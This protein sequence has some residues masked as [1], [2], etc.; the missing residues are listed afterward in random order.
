MRG[1]H[2]VCNQG[3]DG[4]DWTPRDQGQRKAQAKSDWRIDWVDD[5][6]MTMAG[7]SVCFMQWL[8]GGSVAESVRSW[9]PRFQ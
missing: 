3:L 5:E 2:R 1:W 6:Q 9:A 8:D 7:A 4:S